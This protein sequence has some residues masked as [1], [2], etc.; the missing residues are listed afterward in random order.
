MWRDDYVAGATFAHLQPD[1]TNRL[2]R[3][4]AGTGLAWPH[5]FYEEKLLLKYTKQSETRQTLY[6]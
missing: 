6:N 1:S 4:M 2:V 5:V 3:M